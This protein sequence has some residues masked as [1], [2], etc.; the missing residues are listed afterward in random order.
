MTATL[1]KPLQCNALDWVAGALT[2]SVN[3]G[4]W[5]SSSLHVTFLPIFVLSL[6]T[7]NLV[8]GSLSVTECFYSPYFALSF[9]V[10]MP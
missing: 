4:A 1:R 5:K 2:K 7:P 6:Y 3:C 9:G 10:P 8:T